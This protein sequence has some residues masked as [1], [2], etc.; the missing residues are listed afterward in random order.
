MNTQSVAG[1]EPLARGPQD[2]SNAVCQEFTRVVRE[3]LKE[4]GEEIVQWR[5]VV[6]YLMGHP[7]MQN[8]A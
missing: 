6:L 4:Q 1:W 7:F 5:V 8:S 3:S 2:S